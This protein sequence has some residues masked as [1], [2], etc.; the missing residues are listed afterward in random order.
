MKLVDLGSTTCQSPA[1]VAQ[2]FSP[3]FAVLFLASE[4]TLGVFKPLLSGN[5][6][7]EGFATPSRGKAVEIMHYFLA[8]WTVFEFQLGPGHV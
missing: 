4:Y 1:F 8:S 5:F 6:T 7:W 2:H 3:A